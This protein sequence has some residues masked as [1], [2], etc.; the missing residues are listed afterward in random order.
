MKVY[1]VTGPERPFVLPW[2]EEFIADLS[3][4]VNAALIFQGER[5]ITAREL[6]DLHR[7]LLV[8]PSDQLSSELL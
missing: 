8:F 2:R 3:S 4:L 6:A 1:V 7:P 5:L